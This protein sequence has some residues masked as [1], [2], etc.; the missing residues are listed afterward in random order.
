ME[1]LTE[2]ELQ[3]QIATV[4]PAAAPPTTD[5]ARRM[6]EFLADF[7]RIAAIG[8]PG[9]GPGPGPAGGGESA[10]E[11]QTLAAAPTPFLPRTSEEE[12][13]A[14]AT[15][16]LTTL[17]AA[18]AAVAAS[19]EPITGYERRLMR[20]VAARQ[21][22]RRRAAGGLGARLAGIAGGIGARLAGAVGA[23]QPPSFTMPQ[24]PRISP[25]PEFRDY[26]G[27]LP[28]PAYN[29]SGQHLGTSL[30]PVNLGSLAS[31]YQ[32]NGA[33]VDACKS[34]TIPTAHCGEAQIARDVSAAAEWIGMETDAAG[35]QQYAAL[36]REWQD[37]SGDPAAQA[38]KAKE[39]RE[40]YPSRVVK[41]EGLSGELLIANP[42]LARAVRESG[43]DISGS[44]IL[45]QNA[46][47]LDA[48]VPKNASGA[49]IL[50]GRGAIALLESMWHCGGQASLSDDPR[51]LPMRLL[52]EVREQVKVREQE[53]SGDVQ[54]AIAES[55]AGRG[56]VAAAAL[57][58][59]VAGA[60]AGTGTAVDV[61]GAPAAPVVAAPVPATA[62]AAGVAPAVAA[63]DLTTPPAPIQIG[64]GRLRPLLPLVRLGRA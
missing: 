34:R 59:R 35:H 12:Q 13:L 64:S 39:L 46:R 14:A 19:D 50:N 33:R 16:L 7:D 24:V 32:P 53:K 21:Q 4:T 55:V 20:I 36:Y 51:C 38:A 26:T 42:Y 17:T 1:Q 29:A 11:E 58:S 44:S 27:E 9:P 62:T 63:T 28:M 54:A 52:G 2:A 3:E 61:S 41:I 6:D 23:L 47:F 8:A 18:T 48:M 43:T 22:Q 31:F 56:R 49:A 45:E 5:N 37:A 57:L 40:K 60:G 15:A 25:S 10:E 30:P